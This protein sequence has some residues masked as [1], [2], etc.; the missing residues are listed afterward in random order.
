MPIGST[1][2]PLVQ[3]ALLN[4]IETKQVIWFSFE[5]KKKTKSNLHFCCLL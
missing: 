3:L 5:Q 4:K 2:V 1:S